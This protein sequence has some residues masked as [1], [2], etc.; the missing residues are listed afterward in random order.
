[1]NENNSRAS[2]DR[3]KVQMAHEFA[4]PFRS[5]RT[6]ALRR[7][8][9]LE[10]ENCAQIWS[11][12]DDSAHSW[13]SICAKKGSRSAD[14]RRCVLRVSQVVGFEEANRC[15]TSEMLV[16]EYPAEI[17]TVLLSFRRIRRTTIRGGVRKTLEPR[18]SETEAVL[19]F[20]AFFAFFFSS[21][22]ALF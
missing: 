10:A 12:L 20:L 3:Y 7:R 5:A 18:T 21:F 2:R 13:R 6:T 19:H 15:E 16:Y 9:H 14:S 22:C 17:S 1:M 4:A 11:I 8:S